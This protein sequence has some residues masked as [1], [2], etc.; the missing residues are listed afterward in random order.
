MESSDHKRAS[1][2]TSMDTLV[3]V[4]LHDSS[5]NE[6]SVPKNL[7]EEAKLLLNSTVKVNF[8]QAAAIESSTREQSESIDWLNSLNYGCDNEDI[9]AGYYLQYQERHRHQGIKVFP[10]G[11][12]VNPKYS[13]LGASPDRIVY[14]PTSYPIMED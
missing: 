4:P 3:K 12:I 13:W 14:D 5:V 10:C 2:S 7:S 6:V 1:V 8:D 11:L 9:V